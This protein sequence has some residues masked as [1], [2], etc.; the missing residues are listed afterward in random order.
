MQEVTGQYQKSIATLLENQGIWDLGTTLTWCLDGNCYEGRL[1]N[2]AAALMEEGKA[3]GAYLCNPD[4]DFLGM[5]KRLIVLYD[6]KS[7]KAFET[8]IGIV[9]FALREIK[10]TGK[11]PGLEKDLTENIALLEADVHEIENRFK[12]MENQSYSKRMLAVCQTLSGYAAR[13]LGHR[14]QCLYSHCGILGHGNPAIGVMNAASRLADGCASLSSALQ[15]V[16]SFYD[17]VYTGLADAE[18]ILLQLKNDH[19]ADHVD[20]ALQWI[21]RLDDE[22]HKMIEVIENE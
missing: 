2:D 4:N 11:T 14:A 5:A 13:L 15:Y 22:W 6:P 19:P 7:I 8:K 17:R 20:E 16:A 3:G 12:K 10:R 18:N 1:H 9:Q 21:D